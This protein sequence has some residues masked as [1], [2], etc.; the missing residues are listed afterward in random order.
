MIISPGSAHSFRVLV[1]W[2]DVIVVSEFV[3]ADRAYAALLSYLPVQQLPHLSRGSQFPVS[4]RVMRIFNSL[5]SKSDQLGLGYEFSA[6]AGERLV[7][8]A[9]FI[10]AESHGRSP[11]VLGLNVRRESVRK[12]SP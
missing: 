7:N 12:R 9:Q 2:N 8:G 1:V 3:V 10:A 11:E 4:S 5:N 6:T